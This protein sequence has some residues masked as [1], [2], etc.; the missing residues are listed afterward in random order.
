MFGRLFISKYRKNLIAK[1]YHQ[2]VI[3]HFENPR[4]M[5][6]LDKTKKILGLV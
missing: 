4:N 6:S 3:E 2:R 5:G 1:N